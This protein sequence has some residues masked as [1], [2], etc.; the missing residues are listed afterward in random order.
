MANSDEA[1]QTLGRRNSE[2]RSIFSGLIPIT[3]GV[4]VFIS[5]TY[6][7]LDRMH[8]TRVEACQNAL[9]VYCRATISAALMSRLRSL[10]GSSKRAWK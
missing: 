8:M 5:I 10:P 4:I 3:N 6:F 1:I 2:F 9:L 7:V